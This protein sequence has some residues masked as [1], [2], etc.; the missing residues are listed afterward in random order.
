[1]RGYKQGWSKQELARK[2]ADTLRA[3]FLAASAEWNHAAHVHHHAGDE[4]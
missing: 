2:L 1:V 3:K 4:K